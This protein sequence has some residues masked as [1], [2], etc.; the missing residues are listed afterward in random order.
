MLDWKM[1]SKMRQISKT[2][3]KYHLRIKK[4]NFKRKD[5][6]DDGTIIDACLAGIF[7]ADRISRSLLQNPR[8][9]RSEKHMRVRDNFQLT[10]FEL[11]L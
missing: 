11:S 3:F 5:L 9:S 1:R 7:F 2:F 6:T 4:Y 8:V 10:F